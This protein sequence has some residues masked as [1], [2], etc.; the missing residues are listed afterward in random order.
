MQHYIQYTTQTTY[1]LQLNNHWYSR[2]PWVLLDQFSN[3]HVFST[4]NC[5]LLLNCVNIQM[6]S[7]TIEQ[8][9]T[10][11]LHKQ[12]VPTGNETCLNAFVLVEETWGQRCPGNA[13]KTPHHQQLPECTTGK[14]S[15]Q[16]CF[17]QVGCISFD[18]QIMKS[19]K[20]R[21]HWSDTSTGLPNRTTCMEFKMKVFSTTRNSYFEQLCEENASHNSQLTWNIKSLSRV[22]LLRWAT[23]FHLLIKKLEIEPIKPIEPTEPVEPMDPWNPK[24]TLDL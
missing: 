9:S 2:I 12:I 18:G 5:N 7:E 8:W 17:A 20:A 24:S 1:L 4:N 14:K 22:C 23:R 13:H 6:V 16:E 21:P 11:H 10:Q 19:K 15:G 3:S